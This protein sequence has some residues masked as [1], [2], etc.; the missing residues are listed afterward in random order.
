MKRSNDGGKYDEILRA[1]KRKN[2]AQ[3]TD[4]MNAMKKYGNKEKIQPLIKTLNEGHDM[5][6]LVDFLNRK[7]ENGKYQPVLD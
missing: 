4:L 5:E 7:N 2:N 1:V 6:T 3:L